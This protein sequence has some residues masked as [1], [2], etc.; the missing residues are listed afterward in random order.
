VSGSKQITVTRDYRP[1]SGCMQSALMLLLRKPIKE[2]GPDTAPE[3]AV[4]E[5][6]GYD[7]TQNDSR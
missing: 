6:S 4:K 1:D 2:G 7:A 3:D 5:S